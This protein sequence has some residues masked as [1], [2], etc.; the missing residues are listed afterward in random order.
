MGKY[1][2]IREK[3]KGKR[4][5]INFRPYKGSNTIFRNIEAI[6]F[7]DAH[8]KRLDAIAEYR[9][10]ISLPYTERLTTNF[11]E[12][13]E[14]VYQ[15]LLADRLTKKAVGHYHN[16]FIRLFVDFRKKYY[17]HIK[18]PKQLSLPFFKEYNNY[19]VNELNR[20]DGWRAELIFIKSL[21]R[22]L[23]HI[24]YCSKGLLEDLKQ[25]KRPQ[26]NKKDY[27]HI[28]IT[29]IHKLLSFIKKDRQDYYYPICFMFKTGR[30][31]QETTLIKKKDIVLRGFKPISINIRPET[32][33]TK[34]K[35]PITGLD[36]GLERLIR[37]ALSN[38]RSEWLFHDQNG[39]KCSGDGIYEYL[40]KVSQEIIGVS[41]TPHYFRHRFITECAKANVPIADVK[42]VSGIKDN[43]VL[44]EHYSHSTEEGQRQVLGIMKL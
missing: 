29:E 32:T 31:R 10:N 4:Y 12:I 24:G 16:T 41:V 36:E 1:E 42:A 39:K 38:N 17:P 35:A 3:V 22:R 23:Y 43:N 21:V 11:S 15:G 27:P 7:A 14:K 44:L 37:Q 30:R 8:E 5:E 34:K 18:N 19:Y 20:P 13:W 28:P 26:T 40:K 33:K 2:G 9:K 6:S 25:M